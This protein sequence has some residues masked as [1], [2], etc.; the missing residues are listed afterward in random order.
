MYS[1]NGNGSSGSSIPAY[2]YLPGRL[3]EGITTT[4]QQSRETSPEVQVQARVEMDEEEETLRDL[5]KKR[6]TAK[7]KYAIPTQTVLSGH[8]DSDIPASRAITSEKGSKW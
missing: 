7:A 1:D 6:A 8:Q 3:K 4:P 5:K 2:N